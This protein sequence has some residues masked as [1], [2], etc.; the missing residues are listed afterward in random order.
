MRFE[1]RRKEFTF[2]TAPDLTGEAA[3]VPFVVRNGVIVKY[4]GRFVKALDAAIEAAR[5]DHSMQDSGPRGAMVA[6][7]YGSGSR[8][9]G[10]MK[11]PMY[12]SY[13]PRD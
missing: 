1:I 5:M 9:F 12:V 3:Y 11:Y 7:D 6:C 8:P 4:G 13:R 10:A 2:S